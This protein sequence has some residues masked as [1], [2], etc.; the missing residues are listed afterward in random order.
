MLCQRAIAVCELE[1]TD[2]VKS[3]FYKWQISCVLTTCTT[4]NQLN[5]TSFDSNRYTLVKHFAAWQRQTRTT[6]STQTGQTNSVQTVTNTV[7]IDA[8]RPVLPPNT[9]QPHTHTHFTLIRAGIYLHSY[10]YTFIFSTNFQL[11]ENHILINAEPFLWCC[12]KHDKCHAGNVGQLP[13]R[14]VRSIVCVWSECGWCR[15]V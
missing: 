14:F 8:E 3:V 13:L 1:N 2:R 15:S 5:T 4:H 6:S 12:P 9:A 10:I 11:E 7:Y